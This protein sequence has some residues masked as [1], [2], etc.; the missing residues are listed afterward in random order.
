MKKKISREELAIIADRPMSLPTIFRRRITKKV[1]KT[2]K[3]ERIDS[4]NS[5]K[6]MMPSYGLKTK[7]KMELKTATI[8]ASLMRLL[9]AETITTLKFFSIS[10]AKV[11]DA[12]QISKSNRKMSHLGAILFCNRNFLNSIMGTALL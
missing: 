4:W 12:I 8:K 10:V 6:R 2:A 5:E 3:I 7:K 1:Q 9:Y 11:I